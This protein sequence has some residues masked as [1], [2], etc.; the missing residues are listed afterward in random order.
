M[1]HA[2]LAVEL[3]TSTSDLRAT[4][5]AEYLKDQNVQRQQCERK[6]LKQAAETGVFTRSRWRARCA[7]LTS[8]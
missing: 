6:M 4:Q 7:D 3:L 1:G 5:I 2:R 8:N